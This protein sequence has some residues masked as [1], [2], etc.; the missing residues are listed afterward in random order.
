MDLTSLD[1][2]SLDLTTVLIFLGIALVI[3]FFLGLLLGGSRGRDEKP[4]RTEKD[5]DPNWVDV[6]RFWWDQRNNDL[7]FRAGDRTY[8]KGAKIKSAE[9]KRITRMLQDLHTWVAQEPLPDIE[10][11]STLGISDI[12]SPEDRPQA[13]LRSPI[14]SF[15]QALHADIPRA[16]SE[17]E[18][19]REPPAEHLPQGRRRVARRARPNGRAR[20]PVSARDKSTSREQLK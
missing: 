4:T 6:A 13:M 18:D 3:G 12:A 7:V 9:R 16:V 14:S 10:S 1:L 15:A 2:T 19:R 20:R 8:L 11:V 17:P 5:V